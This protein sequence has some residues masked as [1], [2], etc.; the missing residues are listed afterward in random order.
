M[1]Y[2]TK[3]CCMEYYNLQDNSENESYLVGRIT[4]NNYSKWSDKIETFV[5]ICVY[6]A[7]SWKFYPDGRLVLQAD[8]RNKELSD[9]EWRGKD[10]CGHLEYR[11]LDSML[12]DWLDELKLNEGSYDFTEEIKL[13]ESEIKSKERIFDRVLGDYMKSDVALNSSFFDFVPDKGTTYRDVLMDYKRLLETINGDKLHF[14]YDLILLPDCKNHSPILA[15]GRFRDFQQV[16]NE[17]KWLNT[18]VHTTVTQALEEI[19]DHFSGETNMICRFADVI[20][21]G[22]H[23]LYGTCLLDFVF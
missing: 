21:N 7:Y 2:I 14:C 16:C 11:S 23:L 18:E 15:Y 1:K 4:N 12:I 17:D 10:D 8:D 13:I 5:R 20:S 19:E 22:D 3:S 9:F 6:Y